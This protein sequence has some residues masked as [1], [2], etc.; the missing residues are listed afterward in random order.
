MI[1]SILEMQG[2]DVVIAQNGAEALD[3]LDA[4]PFDLVLMDMQ[5]PVMDGLDAT[6]ALRRRERDRHA[7][8]TP[9]IMV[10]ANV[11]SEHVAA[12]LEAGADRHLSK[13]V[14]PD[15]LA[16]AISQ[17]LETAA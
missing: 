4:E 10:T 15:A 16:E 9:V 7:P 11:M 1:R 6:R 14:S 3:R 12:A 17:V 2:Y 8:R 5:M 13:P